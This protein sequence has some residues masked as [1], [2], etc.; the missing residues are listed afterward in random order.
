MALADLIKSGQQDLIR[1]TAGAVLRAKAARADNTE[2]VARLVNLRAVDTR[3]LDLPD[4]IAGGATVNVHPGILHAVGN[5]ETAGNGFEIVHDVQP[6]GSTIDKLRPLAL[7]EPHIF[8]AL[9]FHAFDGPRYGCSYPNHIKNEKGRTPPPGFDRHPY[10]YN[11]AERWGLWATM[12]LLDCEAAIGAI[13]LGRFQQLVGSVTPAAGWKLLK[14]GSA[15]ALFVELFQGEA[16]QL[17]IMLRYFRAHGALGILR[18]GNW[19]EIARVYNGPGNVEVYAAR[20]QTEF[21]RVARH[22]G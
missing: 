3:V 16:A 20:M 18:S 21:Q 9:S 14:F 11:Q 12:A 15:E 1:A 6:D 2:R 10:Q 13:S 8:S 7:V 22:Y 17:E 19:R 5:A 4:F